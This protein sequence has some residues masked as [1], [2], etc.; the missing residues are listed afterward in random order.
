MRNINNKKQH[1]ALIK[2]HVSPLPEVGPKV[3]TWAAL[4]FLIILL[5]A[6]EWLQSYCRLWGKRVDASSVDLSSS[7][8]LCTADIYRNGIYHP[9]S[10]PWHN[11]H[12]LLHFQVL[13]QENWAFKRSSPWRH[14][15]NPREFT[16]STFLVYGW[17]S[18]DTPV[19]PG[20]VSCQS[21]HDFYVVNLSRLLVT[22]FTKRDWLNSPK[23]Y[24]SNIWTGQILMLLLALTALV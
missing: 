6:R 22:F 5:S 16:M 15:R 2:S 12:Y 17:Y 24:V 20:R 18:G 3:F 11:L 9:P 7:T 21:R 13:I 10:R 23:T 8:T 19:I 4:I 1:H 14:I